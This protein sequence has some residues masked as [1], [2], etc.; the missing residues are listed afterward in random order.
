MKNI[1]HVFEILDK[2]GIKMF[3]NYVSFTNDNATFSYLFQC[4]ISSQNNSK[5]IFS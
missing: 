5:I 2:N 3:K 1:L 4:N